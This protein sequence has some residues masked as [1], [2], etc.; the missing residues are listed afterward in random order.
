MR[1]AGFTEDVAKE[2]DD[3]TTGVGKEASPRHRTLSDEEVLGNAFVFIL[4]GHE[5]TANT[6]HFSLLYLAMNPHSQRRVQADV[7]KIFGRRPIREWDYEIDCPKLFGSMIG[8]VM[9]EELRLIPP[10]LDIPKSTPPGQPQALNYG[11][12]KVVVPGGA[13]VSL[14][15]SAVHR[16]PKYWPAGPPKPRIVPRTSPIAK[17]SI[18]NPMLISSTYKG[19]T[20]PLPE[21][22][23]LSRPD[24]EDDEPSNELDQF[25]P[26]RW[27]LDPSQ[28]ANHTA[29]E[30]HEA[31]DDIGGPQGGDTSAQLLR[32]PRGAYI[33]FSEG[34]RSCLGRRF[35]QV[36]VLAVLAVILRDYSVELAVDE[37]TSDEEVAA[38]SINGAERRSVWGKAEA[39]AQWLLKYGMMSVITLKMHKGQVPFRFVKRGKERFAFDGE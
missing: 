7:D 34:Y 39:R 4:A 12:R 2:N 3:V 14:Q 22:A 23:S 20:I 33:P 38:M 31:Y 11:G 30:E 28:A 18:S 25:K 5:T 32:P 10:V 17:S 19:S 37:W 15:T 8:A 13:S 27:L 29:A 9:N 16:N 21:P 35:A 24:A 26:E 36:E 1:G 6:I